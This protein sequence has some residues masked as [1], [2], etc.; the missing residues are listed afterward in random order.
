MRY[1]RETVAV[2]V[3][4]IAVLA[5][6]TTTAA[7]AG[8]TTN[9]ATTNPATTNYVALG[10]SYS[11]GAG[12]RN[13]QPDSGRC[14]RSPD[15]Y[16]QL[17]SRSHGVNHFSFNACA[18]ATTDDVV[19]DQLGA[20]DRNTS[21]VTMTIGGNDVGFS[22]VVGHCLVGDDAGC[23]RAIDSAEARVRDELP[24][25]LDKAFR[26][27]AAKAPNAKV[28][29]LGYPLINELGG[30]DIPGYTEAKREA[31]NKGAD[32]L[33]DVVAQHA[34]SAGLNYADARGHFKGHSVCSKDPWIN[35]PTLPLSE[36][37][38]PNV[39][40][41]AHGYLPVLDAAA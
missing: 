7:G 12:T 27:V 8:S 31:I 17:W 32:L 2:V 33:D 29:V 5:G 21:L 36:S 24:G 39:D 25:K 40:G 16:P 14:L 34:R 19:A 13:Y 22:S 38:H 23:G 9:P 15:A 35:G 41:H 28:I 30:C 37:F 3:A 6:T 4:V 26:A 11:S 10:D 20:L 1:V 18:G